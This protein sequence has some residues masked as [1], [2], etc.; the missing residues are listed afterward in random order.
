MFLLAFFGFSNHL[1]GD[2]YAF[3]K[4]KHGCKLLQAFVSDLTDKHTKPIT[5]EKELI[6]RALDLLD[7]DTRY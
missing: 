3:E 1:Y 5:D 4:T 7:N 6:R 2:E